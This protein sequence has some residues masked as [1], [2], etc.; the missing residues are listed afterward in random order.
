MDATPEEWRP[1]PGHEGAYEVSD[2]GQ[3]RSLDRQANTWYG[4]RTVR[5]R[6]LRP[7]TVKGKYLVVS[8][9]RGNLRSV[10]QLVAEAFIGP[11]PDGWHTCH[12]DGD[13]T[14]NRADNLRYDTPAANCMDMVKHG[15]HR[16][17]RK[18]HCAKGHPYDDA[19][20]W[21]G[22][23]KNGAAQRICRTCRRENMRTYNRA[24]RLK[25][26]TG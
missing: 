23:N 8:L 24:K 10:H 1:I 25:E 6:T 13:S 15:T 19:N 12:N 26:T 5:G 16:H 4:S 9:G 17:A 7:A 3:V 14:N 22:T 21:V 18:S 2:H 11:I 20:T